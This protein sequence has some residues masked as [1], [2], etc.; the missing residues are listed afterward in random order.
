MKKRYLAVASVIIL[1]AAITGCATAPGSK[2]ALPDAEPSSIQAEAEGLSPTGDAHYHSLGLAL[3]VGSVDSLVT[4]KVDIM[5]QKQKTIVRSFAGTPA[6]L[7]ERLVWDG[8]D[9][10]GKKAAEGTYVAQLSVAYAD[11]FKPATAVSKPF[12]LDLSP[13]TGSFSASPPQFPYSPD[14]TTKP[15]TVTVSLKAGIAKVLRWTIEVYDSDGKLVKS[16]AGTPSALQVT[17]DGKTDGGAYVQTGA[18]YPAVLSIYDQFGNRGSSKGVFVASGIPGAENSS[19]D[20]RRGGFSPTSQSVKNS[21]DLI[22]VIGSKKSLVSWQVQVQSASTGAVRSYSGDAGNVP[23]LLQWDGKDDK[24]ALV[25]EGSYYATLSVDY[26]KAFKP[27]KAQSRPF[28]LVTSAPSGSITVDPPSIALAELGPKKPVAF[29]IQ[30]KSPFAQISDWILTVMDGSGKPLATFKANWPNNKA[31]W[32]GSTADG[33]PL[34]PNAHY[35]VQAKVQ[36]EYGNVGVLQGSLATD[37]LPAATEPSTVTALAAGFAPGGDR[38]GEVMRFDLSVGNAESLASWRLEIVAS[39]GTTAKTMSG[40]KSVPHAL[41]WDGKTDAKTYAR[42]GMYKAVLSLDYGFNFAPTKASS[43]QFALDITPP[44]G[45]LSF[46]TDLFSPDGDGS[47][48]S[49]TITM[50]GSSR[51]ARI[52]SWTMT[53]YDPGNNPFMSWKGSWPAAP[54]TWDGI[55][56]SGD[57]VESASDYP[58]VLVLRDEFGNLGESRKTIKTDILVIKVGEGYRIR[59]PSIVFKSFTADY[60]DVPADQAQRNLDTLDLLARKLARFPDYQIR[61]EGHAVMI[62]WDNKAKGEAEQ[63]VVLIPLSQARADAIKAALVERGIP[64]ANISSEG[65]GAKDPIVP[66]SDFANRWKNRRVEFFL[67]K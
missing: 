6:D 32:D 24:G 13:P 45:T 57:S 43:A 8:D 4:W 64:A 41:S 42:E 35:A 60:K 46:S 20:A 30:A 19:I 34:V 15:L 54:I 62:N 3:L 66:D 22:M 53:V 50:G 37:G 16:L 14:G 52:Q 12:I 17:W 38:P 59:V 25:A 23:S 36:D 61:L 39:D 2:A 1:L 7:P 65:V 56:S 10:S 47:S 48:D 5:D 33:A 51:L 49:I 21:L 29:T 44:A 67:V 55:G 40:V 18:S 28:S 26:G 11:K 9:G 63:R 31:S 27:A 58:V